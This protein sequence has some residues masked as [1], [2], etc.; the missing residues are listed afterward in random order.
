M[1]EAIE[2]GAAIAAGII[3]V[4][5]AWRDLTSY[6]I[7]NRLSVLL[8][9]AFPVAAIGGGMGIGDFLSHAAVGAVM[10]VAGGALFFFRVF[11]GGDAKLIAAM[12]LWTGGQL[13]ARFLLWVCLAGGLL[14]FALLSLRRLPIAKRQGVRPWVADLL[15]PSR[16]VPYGV[17][18]AAG[19]LDF[20]AAQY[21][22]PA[23]RAFL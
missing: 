12:S 7:P 21:F 16:G 4:C 19:A 8:A 9:A 1:L 6:T 5:A 3:V 13:L 14:A 20:L 18:I 15:S 17:A 10:L 2:T 23:L 11:G 22:L